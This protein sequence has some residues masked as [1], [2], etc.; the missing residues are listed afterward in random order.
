MRASSTVVATREHSQRLAPEVLA[1]A[2][3]AIAGGFGFIALLGWILGF[4]LLTSLGPGW[5]PMAPSTAL[6]FLLFGTAL[7]LCA[8]TPLSRGTYRIGMAV[9][10]AGAVVALLLLILSLLG[11][12]LQAEHLGIAISG[13]SN[14]KPIGHISPLAA[15]SFVLAGLSLVASLA[16][17]PDRPWRALAGFVFACLLVF[18][19]TVFLLAYLFGTP[20]LYSGKFI[21]PALTTSLAFAALGAGLWVLA[22][23]RAWATDKGD[24]RIDAASLRASRSLILVFTLVGAGLVSAGYLYFQHQEKDY[25]AHAEQQLSAIADLK[26]S[27]LAEYREERLADGAVFY[28]NAAFAALVRRA[29]DHPGDAQAE[30]GLREWLARS[31]ASVE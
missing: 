3:A 19:G 15:L 5:I 11:I 26:L 22:G 10:S 18:A 28:R 21:P 16:S 2:C 6:L 8:G 14:G 25:R 12:A 4:P 29:F 20:V 13:T 27:E 17:S 24:D 23:S 31:S 9:G 7:I 30:A 1:R